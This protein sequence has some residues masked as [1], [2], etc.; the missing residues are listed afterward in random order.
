[1]PTLPGV[2]EIVI[3]TLTVY[4]FLLAGVRLCGKREVGQLMPFDFVLLLVL[5]NSVQNAMLGP[6]SSLGGGLVAAGTLLLLTM[7][8]GRI[9]RRNPQI[10]RWLEGTPTTL[11][12]HGMVLHRNLERE[13]VTDEELQQVLREHEVSDAQDVELATLE[14]D[15]NVSVIRRRDETQPQDAGYVRTRRH[16]RR[17]RVSE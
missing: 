8:L 15:G 5:S 17:Q 12:A 9:G 14:V 2:T 1:M 13:G 10:R 3:R 7:A 6:D 11:I 16:L 4:A